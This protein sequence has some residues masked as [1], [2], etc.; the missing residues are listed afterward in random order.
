[1]EEMNAMGCLWG[2]GGGAKSTHLGAKCQCRGAMI[3][4][5]LVSR[6]MMKLGGETMKQC[7]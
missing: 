2:A 7:T 4:M 3:L 1:M 6:M 5:G